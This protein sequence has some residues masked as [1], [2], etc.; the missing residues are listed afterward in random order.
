VK[1]KPDK[2]PA[3]GPLQML[4]KFPDGYAE[5][6]AA[7]YEAH[8]SRI[9]LEIM[10]NPAFRELAETI[11]TEK[12]A[13]QHHDNLVAAKRRKSASLATR[14][15]RKLGRIKKRQVKDALAKGRDP[16]ASDRHVRRIVKRG[17]RRHK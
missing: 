8:Q 9:R 15:R 7:E 14:S 4:F 3:A 11:V 13:R 12:A 1:R 6:P 5:I 17:K 10:T 16:P 2:K